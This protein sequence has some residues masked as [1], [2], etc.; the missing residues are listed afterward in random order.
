MIPLIEY[1]KIN[2]KEVVLVVE[3]CG[4]VD[5]RLIFNKK[6]F[7]FQANFNFSQRWTTPVFTVDK[8]VDIL[9]KCG[10]KFKRVIKIKFYN[11]K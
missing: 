1:L 4:K 9:W 3:C 8:V 5:N 6:A 2:N 11:S 10:Q 7:I